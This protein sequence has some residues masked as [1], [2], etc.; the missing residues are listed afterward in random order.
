MLDLKKPLQT[1][2]G[3]KVIEVR[4]DLNLGSP[5]LQLFAIVEQPT[6]EHKILMRRLDGTLVP[7]EEH[8]DDIV[9]KPEKETYVFK[10]TYTDDAE[11]MPYIEGPYFGSL[12]NLPEGNGFFR[13][14]IKDCQLIGVELL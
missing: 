2:D 6:G 1:R 4:T 14:T 7:G 5:D 10:F 13:L 12:E 3:R 11:P 9:N 8:K